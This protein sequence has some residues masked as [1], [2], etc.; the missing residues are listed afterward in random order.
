MVLQKPKV[1]RNIR[2]ISRV[3]KSRFFAVMCVSESLFSIA[4]LIHGLSRLRKSQNTEL[5]FFFCK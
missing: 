2:R 5:Y 1:A 3:S 4:K